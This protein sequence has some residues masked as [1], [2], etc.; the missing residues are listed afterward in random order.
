[1]GLALLTVAVDL[2]PVADH[3]ETIAAAKALLHFLNGVLCEFYYFSTIYTAK[4]AV[5]LMAIYVF[6]MSVAGLEVCFLDE[7]AFEEQ[8]DGPVDGGL[9]NLVILPSE[10][11]VE[12]IHV[13]MI[14]NGKD[15]PDYFLSL[16]GIPQSFSVDEFPEDIDFV[17]HD[18]GLVAIALQ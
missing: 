10:P 5:V 1:M 2:E 16:G 3:P 4:M 6:I 18:P 9:G 13:E 8:G 14:M 7:A 11:L 17:V 12:F 15:H